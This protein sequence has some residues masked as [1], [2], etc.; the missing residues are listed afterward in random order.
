MAA[1]RHIHR[2]HARDA[3][4]RVSRID[5]TA[6][7]FSSRS[8]SGS[9]ATSFEV[10]SQLERSGT[11]HIRADFD[12]LASNNHDHVTI[13]LQNQTLSELD[14]YFFQ[15]NGVRIEGV[16]E[17]A[18]AAMEIRRGVLSG[19]LDARYRDL[20]V[21]Y[22]PVLG[23]SSTGAFFSDALERLLTKTT[24][25]QPRPARAHFLV[26]REP[27]QSV[28]N[29]MLAGLRP[30]AHTILTGRTSSE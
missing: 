5:G 30:A 16:L 15:D 6:H 24:Q 28:I 14:P 11:C 9:S 2:A 3:V 22:D 29:F 12:L 21:H 20:V 18:T 17:H 7:N 13:E 1:S 26:K 19:D 8:E 10:S 23:R 25:Q 27:H 4:I